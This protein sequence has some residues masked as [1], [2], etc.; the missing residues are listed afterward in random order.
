M[1]YSRP[2]SAIYQSFT[3]VT[4]ELTNPLRAHISGGHAQLMRYSD[5][6][7]KAQIKLGEY[8][9]T[10]D[11]S[12]SWPGRAVG[13]KVDQSYAKL[14]ID[15]AIMEYFNDLIGDTSGG[16][17]TIQAVSGYSNKVRSAGSKGFKENGASYPRFDDLYTRDVQ[18]GDYVKLRANVSGTEYTLDTYVVDIEGDEVAST[19]S[20][21]E[22]DV[23]N[24]STQSASQSVTPDAGNTTTTAL[25]ADASAYNGYYDGVLNETYTVE[26]ISAS[27]G[28]DLTTAL[29]RIT[30]ASGLDDVDSMNPAASGVAFTA[31]SRNLSLT[32]TGSDD[33]ALGDKWTVVVTAPFEAP[34][35]YATG[36][37]TGTVDTKYIVEVTRGGLFA[38]S[39]PNRR[40]QITVTTI[41]GNDNSGPTDVTGVDVDLP[42]GTK[43]VKI[44]FYGSDASLSLSNGDI[45]NPDPLA[46]LRKGDRFYIDVT[47][48]KEG[49]MSTLVLGHSLPAGMEAATDMDLRLYIKKD[50]QVSKNRVESP[51][52]VN[53]ETSDTEITVKSGITAF[54]SSWNDNNGD[55]LPLPVM[56]GT[57]YAEYR[58]WLSDLTGQVNAVAD[59]GELDDAVSGPLT[60]DNPLKWALFLAT[61][62]SGGTL[63]K[64]T[65]VADPDDPDSWLEVLD[66][67][68]SRSDVYNLVPLTDNKTVLDAYSGHVQTQSSAERGRW[69]AMFVSLTGNT[70]KE[71][72]SSNTS[73]DGQEVLATL[74]DDPNTS[75]TQYTL[76]K[77]TSGNASLLT[78]GVKAGD[79]VRYLYQTSFGE[80]TYTE[81]VVDA[82][83]SE[84]SLRLAEGHS[85][86]INVGQKVEIWHPLSK[87]EM[88]EDIGDQAASYGSSRVVAVWPD[89]VGSGE[90][91]FDGM[92]LCAALAGL[93]SGVVPHQGL[94]NVKITGFDDVSRSN[95]MFSEDQ[96]DT[97]ASKG[98]WIVMKADDGSIITRHALTTDMTDLNTQE[99]MAR[100]NADSLSYMFLNRM[101]PFIGV[102]NVT[103]SALDVIRANL[104]AAIEF[105]RSNSFVPTL[106]A[107][108]IS[109]RIV[110][111]R[112]HADFKDR[113]VAVLELERPFPLNRLEVYLVL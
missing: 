31:G 98:V 82:V 53:Y 73:S 20:Q 113:I 93:R 61:S 38:D 59:P 72:I 99:E 51:P 9:P 66:L 109:G 13:S 43:G 92:F 37:Y 21:P 103:P 79:V 23:D 47:A 41:H 42:V 1:P 102:A 50:I 14:F 69:R 28:G 10:Q 36:T 15:D 78:D 19:I 107:Q 62:N 7:E 35:T 5:A 81:F 27:V 44:A 40:P 106:G 94:T 54:D 87:S 76:L 75:G 88:A 29:I 11:V 96:L 33:L 89:I 60:P 110:E 39:D 70:E 100:V 67:L 57:M 8:D 58:A 26:V 6:D 17:G 63:V 45:V 34:N 56:G 32:F 104:Q 83:L 3:T 16:R 24:P 105:A 30:S 49:R 80:E 12:Y 95:E 112:P 71:V 65:A 48:A 97:I 18:A 77:I 64:Y 85:A 108:L 91:S 90:E 25:A 46:G 111:L 86:A 22:A 68:T 55:P 2:I 52:L 101:A 84:D 4:N 74:E